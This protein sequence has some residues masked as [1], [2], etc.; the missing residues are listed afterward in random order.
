MR[1]ALEMGGGGRVGG[2]KQLYL[3]LVEPNANI[4]YMFFVFTSDL[5]ES[6][7][8]W[9]PR[10]SGKT[11]LLRE[12]FSQSIRIDLLRNSEFL[13]YSK[14]P[15]ILGTELAAIRKT[16]PPNAPFPFVCIDEIQ[17]VPTL[18]DEVHRLIEE[19][20][21][22]FALTGSSARKLRR[23]HANLLGGRALRYELFGLVSAE[24][25]EMCDPVRFIN[26]G[27]LPRH[28]DSERAS[29]LLRGYVEDY[30][31]EEVAA[32]GL[33]RNLPVFADFLKQA[34]ISD[35]E[36]VSFENIARE[37]GTS[38]KSVKEYFHILEDTLLGYFVPSFIRREKRRVTKSP[39]FYFRDVGTA[40]YIAER[41]N[42][43]PGN[44][45]F[46]K[47]FENWLAHEIKSY[48]S[49]SQKYFDVSYWRLTSGIEVDFILGDME[50]AIWRTSIITPS[51]DN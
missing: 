36:I 21:I 26:R 46:G 8:L 45:L 51:D 34:A 4:L 10:Q 27:T 38:A 37:C 48:S 29:L 42:L 12:R 40:N 16:L 7:F 20:K 35:S 39:K 1:G 44:E 43:L 50:I 6:F 11:T 49:Y 30:L 33:V 28:F 5:N 22:H 32:E 24:V 9:G 25:G 47:S 3:R 18:L 15:E 19:E 23:G 17:K 31:K 14:N 41:K 2:V 13:R